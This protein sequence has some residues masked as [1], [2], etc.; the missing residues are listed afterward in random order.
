MGALHRVTAG[1]KVDALKG[2]ITIYEWI[3]QDNCMSHLEI[4]LTK[5]HTYWTIIESGNF[6]YVSMST[7]LT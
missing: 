6:G 4:I 5:D 7:A 2:P 3:W 1:D